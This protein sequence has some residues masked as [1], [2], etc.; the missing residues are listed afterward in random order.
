MLSKLKCERWPRYNLEFL[1]YDDNKYLDFLTLLVD[2]TSHATI[3]HR[4]PA[5]LERFPAP[6]TTSRA[7]RASGGQDLGHQRVRG[8]AV[9]GRTHHRSRGAPRLAPALRREPGRSRHRRGARGTAWATYSRRPR[10][11]V[12]RR[13]PGMPAGPCGAALLLRTDARAA[14]GRGG[15]I[16]RVCPRRVLLPGRTRAVRQRVSHDVRRVSL[17]TRRGRRRR[18][19]ECDAC[20]AVRR[21]T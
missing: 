3:R 7:R 11:A 19:R 14:R 2:H 15:L 9:R 18:G 8:C 16:A 4:S 12:L 20:P 5:C 1:A 17:G 6:Q 13:D 21:R 10:P